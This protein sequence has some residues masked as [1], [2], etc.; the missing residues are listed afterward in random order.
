MRRARHE[1]AAGPPTSWLREHNR[2]TAE[3][4]F[5]RDVERWIE[6]EMGGGDDTP[7]EI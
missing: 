6:R 2:R 5:R 7:E 1:V 3:T 4:L